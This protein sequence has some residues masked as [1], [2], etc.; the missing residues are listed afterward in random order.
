MISQGDW[1]ALDYLPHHLRSD[2]FV[3]LPG[4]LFNG[5]GSKVSLQTI[6]NGDGT[7]ITV[8]FAKNKH[9]GSQFQLGI[10][11]FG[12]QL[13]TPIITRYPQASRAQPLL[14]LSAIC[15]GLFADSQYAYL[16]RSKPE[17][18]GTREMLD[19]DP[20]EPLH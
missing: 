5:H 2:F 9:V 1:V 13:G 7:C 4:G 11:D 10:P 19:Q 6:S 17:R 16:L 3:K 18:K 15:F 14:D 8:F 12:A 20:N